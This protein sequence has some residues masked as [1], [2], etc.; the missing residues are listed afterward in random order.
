MRD[1]E[2]RSESVGHYYYY[3]YYY[4]YFFF[5]DAKLYIPNIMFT[6]AFISLHLLYSV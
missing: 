1:K 6:A 2:K 4:Y 5:L 3:Y